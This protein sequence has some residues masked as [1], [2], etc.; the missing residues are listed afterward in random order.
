MK[1]LLATLGCVTVIGGGTVLAAPSAHAG[2]GNCTSR[3]LAGLP[4]NPSHH[5]RYVACIFDETATCLEWGGQPNQ[6]AACVVD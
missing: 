5:L 1:R 2:V 4:G 6:I 3:Y